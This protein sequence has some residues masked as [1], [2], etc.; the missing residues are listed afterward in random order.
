MGRG[1]R[2]E[3][4]RAIFFRYREAS[5]RDK[6]RILEEF[7]RVCEYNRKYAIRKLNGR[8]RGRSRP[9]SGGDHDRGTGRR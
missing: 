5:G 8:L 2:W 9:E 4:F 6:S 7:C 1:S 3:Y